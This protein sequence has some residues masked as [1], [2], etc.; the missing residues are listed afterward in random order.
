MAPFWS[1]TLTNDLLILKLFDNKQ[2]ISE[3]MMSI[4]KLKKP[5]LKKLPPRFKPSLDSMSSRVDALGH[6]AP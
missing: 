3:Q 1:Q 6:A 2:I 5:V 4:E